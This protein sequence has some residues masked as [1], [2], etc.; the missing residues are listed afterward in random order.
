MGAGARQDAA[1]AWQTACPGR[2][3]PDQQPTQRAF[4]TCTF[5]GH[6]GRLGRPPVNQPPI[7]GTLRNLYVKVRRLERV[8]MCSGTVPGVHRAIYYAPALCRARAHLPGGTCRPPRTPPDEN[9]GGPR[10]K[11]DSA[12]RL[13]RALWPGRPFGA[14][15][16][17]HFATAAPICMVAVRAYRPVAA[18]KCIQA[19]AML[20][21]TVHCDLA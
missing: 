13:G 19:N 11:P 8:E 1:A 5:H 21:H 12:L 15:Q 7:Q 18:L 3:P 9:T 10:A 14:W 6:V 16:T 2:S 4:R 17:M 20:S